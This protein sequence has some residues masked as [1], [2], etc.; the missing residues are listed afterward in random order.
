MSDV[1]SEF[2][3]QYKP[4]VEAR[5]ELGLPEP[6]T[7]G[8]RLFEAMRYSVLNGGKRIRPLLVLATAKACGAVNDVAWAGVVAVEYVHAYSLIH[9]DLPAMDDDNLRRGVPTCHIAY[10]EATAILAGDALQCL[11]FEY[12]CEQG[13]MPLLPILA[14][15]AGA[16]GM[17]VGQ[18]I[19][20]SA[21]N[22][23]LSLE[24]LE[25]MHHHKT[26]ALISAS[27]EM[28]G[29]AANADVEQM[30]ALRRYASA[31]GLAFQVQD[32]ILDVVSDTQT[33]GKQQGADIAANKPTY[34]SLLGLEQAQAKAEGLIA[35]AVE[36]V[37]PLGDKAD[38]LVAI[39]EYIIRRRT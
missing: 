26:G 29:V 6:V 30:Q 35:S 20:L 22:S 28:G 7:G 10:D 2:I 34:V 16:R 24:Q 31:I 18:S 15:A 17:V 33:L 9:D 25:H 13:A 27:V 8:R 12:L 37:R 32:D 11:A 21:V 23:E 39:A 4:L 5:L 1:L 14:R 3:A 38:V 19:D 36:S